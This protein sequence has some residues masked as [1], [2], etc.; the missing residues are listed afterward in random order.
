M[1]TVAVD[2]NWVSLRELRAED[3]P[4]FIR[5]YTDPA[6][7]K[8]L[9]FDCM[10]IAQAVAAFGNC[11]RQRAAQ[12]RCRYTL[13]IT[14]RGDDTMAGVIGLLVEDYGSNAML[15]GLATLPDTPVHGRTVE[16]ARLLVS[17]GFGQ[18][19]LNRIWAGRRHDHARMHHFLIRCGL[20]QE[21]Y[22]RQLFRT[23]GKWHDVVTYAAVSAEWAP[24]QSLS[25]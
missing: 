24:P 5:I 10:D 20:R 3:L 12:P 16:A 8:Y 21:A 14:A 6:I 13:A 4:A 11:L 9:G 23:Q 19:G 1:D 18:L 17:L 2:G 25:A 15:T 22:L 7:T